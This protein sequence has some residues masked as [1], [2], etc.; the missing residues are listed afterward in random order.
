MTEPEKTFTVWRWTEPRTGH[1]NGPYLRQH[2]P[3]GATPD[4]FIAGRVRLV[5]GPPVELRPFRHAC[6]A[7]GRE[8]WDQ[9]L[10]RQVLI[11]NNCDHE[12][13]TK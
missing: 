12:V 10:M 4:D 3:Q 7:C 11:C 9:D 8:S 13:S 1:P 5:E 6:H 2:N